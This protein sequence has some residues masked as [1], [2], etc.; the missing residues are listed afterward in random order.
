MR[1]CVNAFVGMTFV[2]RVPLTQNVL[3]DTSRRHNK[4]VVCQATS[5][6]LKSQLIH[7]GEVWLATGTDVRV[8]VGHGPR[9]SRFVF[10]SLDV[11]APVDAIWGSLTDYDHLE[12]F[13]PS[14]AVNECLERKPTGAILKQARSVHKILFYDIR[15]TGGSAEYRTG[16]QILRIGDFGNW[17]AFEWVKSRTLLVSE[18]WP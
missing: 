15:G 7:A 10:A 6:T 5:G 2:T 14:L 1:V 11:K 18:E 16:G 3:Q 4:S 17:R 9:N 13:I 8:K 12:E